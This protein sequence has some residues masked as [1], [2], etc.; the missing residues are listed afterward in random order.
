M[1]AKEIQSLLSGDEAMVLFVVTV[2]ESYVLAITRES[3]DWKPVPAGYRARQRCVR[4]IR[5]VRSG[6]R[7]EL[8]GLLP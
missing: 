7:H 6:A 2:K 3:L 1:T 4:Q 5:A 8:Y